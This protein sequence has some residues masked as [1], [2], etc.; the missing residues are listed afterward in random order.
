MVAR[1]DHFVATFFSFLNSRF[2]PAAETGRT[3]EVRRDEEG[4]PMSIGS[5]PFD[6]D[7]HLSGVVLAQRARDRPRQGT[8][9]R[10][11]RAAFLAGCS[12]SSRFGEVVS[13][14]WSSS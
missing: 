10:A 6:A 2:L 5:E 4:P 13:G 3:P 9:K 12:A 1:P 14:E 11:S 8:A 7:V